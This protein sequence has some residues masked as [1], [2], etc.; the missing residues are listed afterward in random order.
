MFLALRA[1]EL[2]RNLKL[3]TMSTTSY[4]VFLS[5]LNHKGAR[6]NTTRITET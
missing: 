1:S 4:D 6:K 2:C 5:R 3:L